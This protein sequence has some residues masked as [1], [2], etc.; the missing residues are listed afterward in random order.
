MISDSSFKTIQS[1][2]QLIGSLTHQIFEDIQHEDSAAAQ[3]HSEQLEDAK[4][5]LSE[6]EKD[7]LIPN[8]SAGIDYDNLS[9]YQY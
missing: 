6:L 3:R 4:I 5:R 8:S 9:N 7:N 1:L 2:K